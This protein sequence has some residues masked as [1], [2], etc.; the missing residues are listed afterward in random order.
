MHQR[1]RSSEPDVNT[2]TSGAA[3]D[4]RGLLKGAAALVGAAAAGFP[5]VSTV[6]AAQSSTATAQKG[7]PL[8]VVTGNGSVADT[9]SG[10]VRGA[11]RL[12]IHAF[13]GIPYGASTA[14]A[15]FMPPTKPAPWTGVRSSLY[16]GPVA[17]HGP[18][19]GWNFDE[20]S[21]MFEWDDGQPS[22]DCLRVNVWTP[23]LDARKRPVLVWL[24]GGGFS[25]GSS[26]EL[27]AYDGESMARRGDVVVVSLNHRLNVLGYLNL[28]AYGEKYA[29]AGNVGMLDIVL[30]LEWVRDNIASFGGDAG[31]V[32]I[33]GQS[34]GGAKVSSLMA[35]PS[36]RGL[37]HRAAVQSASSLRMGGADG[38]AKVAAGTLA[39][40]GL[41]AGQADQLQAMP[42]ERLLGAAEA[43]MRKL[44][45]GDAPNGV[46]RITTG[47]RTGFVPFVD[48]KILPVHPFDPVAPAL[49]AGVPMLIG[50][51]FNENGHSLNRPELE[52][53]TD[54][55]L[56]T[57]VGASYGT[58]GNMI[59]EAYRSVYPKAKPFDVLSQVVAAV[60]RHNAVTQATRKAA[61]AGA[62]AYLY[63]F[64]WQTPILDGRPRAFHCAELPFVF[65]NTDRCAAMTG[66][67]AEAR[68]LGERVSD[69]WINFARSGNPNHKG[70]PTWPA[71]NAEQG[72]VMVFDDT[73]EVKNDPDR[74]ARRVITS[75][76]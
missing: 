69:A 28:A 57:R 68:A 53:M 38:T 5:G 42:Y 43:A 54:A 27:K 30:G 67:T 11:R 15:R 25:N 41:T 75:A 74:A 21:F 59:V 73:C 35:M 62:P 48:G 34:G 17:P 3:L 20:E 50:C 49:T 4:R 10:K 29:G 31:N 64:A 33:F 32:T 60:H 9:T 44:Q 6:V 52:N 46:R 71:F 1:N 12:D 19:N 56:R 2:A 23:G 58:S 8:I 70:L 72:P 22:E 24:H 55:E 39:E 13:K 37:F 65:N 26:Q 40:L 36:A 51:C 45:P 61:L 66:G 47:D 63:L 7:S 18:R 16:Y 14:G 76:T